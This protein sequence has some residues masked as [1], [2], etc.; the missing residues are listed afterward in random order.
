MQQRSQS[1]DVKE[2]CSVESFGI[3][4]QRKKVLNVVSSS[5]SGSMTE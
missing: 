5:G 4:P 3:L 1:R 2:D